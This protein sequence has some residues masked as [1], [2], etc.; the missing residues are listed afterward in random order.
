[1]TQK[2][3]LWILLFVVGIV[4][5]VIVCGTAQT[6]RPSAPSTESFDR[7]FNNTSDDSQIGLVYE[8][9]RYGYKLVPV[10]HNPLMPEYP[11]ASA[12]YFDV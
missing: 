5:A 7:G 2:Q 3:T 9:D 4:F 10:P 1:M 6:S 8:V 12:T 11:T